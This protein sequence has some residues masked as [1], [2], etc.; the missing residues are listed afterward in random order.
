[1]VVTEFMNHPYQGYP[2]RV[3]LDR[4]RRES[5][6]GEAKGHHGGEVFLALSI[7]HARPLPSRQN[8]ELRPLSSSVVLPLPSPRPLRWRH[9]VNLNC[10]TSVTL[11]PL[12][13]T[14]NRIETTQR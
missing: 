11:G 2:F 8:D 1:M 5:A 6:E 3:P 14:P 9:A 13:S 12:E 4:C 7:L 10:W